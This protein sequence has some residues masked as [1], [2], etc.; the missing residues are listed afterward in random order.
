MTRGE[1]MKEPLISKSQILGSAGSSLGLQWGLS[2]LSTK[3]VF[4]TLLD[5]AQSLISKN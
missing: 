4:S 3:E 1:E 5:Q 2:P